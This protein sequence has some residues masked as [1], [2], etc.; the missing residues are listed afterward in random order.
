MAQYSS[1]G[2]S[3]NAAYRKNTNRRR[4]VYVR[5]SPK[6]LADRYLAGTRR[7][8]PDW[9]CGGG[10]IA[11]RGIRAPGADHGTEHLRGWPLSRFSDDHRRSAL[12][13]GSRFAEPGP[14]D[15]HFVGQ[16]GDERRYDVVPLGKQ[17][18]RLV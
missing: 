9:N 18:P 14:S 11:D 5:A 13:G 1:V 10:A 3:M 8:R 4:R 16:E 2:A 7:L 17:H 12:G 6:P 15:Q